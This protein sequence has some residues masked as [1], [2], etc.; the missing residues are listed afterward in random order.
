MVPLFTVRPDGREPAPGSGADKHL[1]RDAC[2]G[3]LGRLFPPFCQKGPH[4]CAAIFTFL[5]GGHTPVAQDAEHGAFPAAIPRFTSS[6]HPS[7]R[8]HYALTPQETAAVNTSPLS[9]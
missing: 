2:A 5:C 9:C 6:V 4:I 8:S 3:P 7:E 1:L